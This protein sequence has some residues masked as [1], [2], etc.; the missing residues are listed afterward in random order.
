[1]NC[2]IPQAKTNS[3]RI[4]QGSQ[5]RRTAPLVAG[6]AAALSDCGRGVVS[7]EGWP[8][9]LVASHRVF[10]FQIF[11]KPARQSIETMAATTSTSHG[12]WKFDTR[13]C[14]MAKLTPQTSSAGQ[15]CHMP[16]RPAKAAT[17]QKGTISEKNGSCRPIIPDSSSRSRPVTAASAMTGV[18]SAP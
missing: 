11:R 15:T 2:G 10:G 18:P 1:M 8:S 13:Y 12:P 4:T 14:G 3:D 6:A 17:T 7:T 9:R 5:A 16:R